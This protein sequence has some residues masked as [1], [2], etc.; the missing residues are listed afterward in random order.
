MP[1]YINYFTALLIT[2][3]YVNMQKKRL[4][5]N[6]IWEYYNWISF[7]FFHLHFPFPSP[8]GVICNSVAKLSYRTSV[9]ITNISF[10]MDFYFRFIKRI[11]EKA[12]HFFWI[13][14]AWILTIGEEVLL[15]I[16][17]L[18]T[19]FLLSLKFTSTSTSLGF[20]SRR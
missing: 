17:I 10:F 18:S 20:L 1:Y 5:A 3:I 6:S 8:K 16:S 2:T 13:T 9:N 12:H 7:S 11:N 19:R 15:V 14:I 4:T